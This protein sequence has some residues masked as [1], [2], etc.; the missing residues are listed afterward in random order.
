MPPPDHERR[1]EASVSTPIASVELGEIC[2]DATMVTLE[3]ALA[4]PEPAHAVSE[5]LPGASWASGG[6]AAATPDDH[7]VRV[8]DLRLRFGAPE[9]YA[10]QCVCGWTGDEHRGRTGERLARRD[11]RAHA[12]AERLA[13]HARK[14]G[15]HALS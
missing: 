15:R 6:T 4:P 2:G 11:G 5:A 7:S 10:A 9:I 12:E 3:D 8:R 13:L 14:P 1:L